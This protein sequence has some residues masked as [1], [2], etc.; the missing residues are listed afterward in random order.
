MHLGEEGQACLSWEPTPDPLEPTAHTTGYILY[1]RIDDAGFDDGRALDES[2]AEIALE[3]GHLYS[4]RVSATNEG[5][6]SFPSEVLSVGVVSEEAPTVLVVNN[7]DRVSA[8]VSFASRDSSYAGFMNRLDGGVPWNYDISY[9][10]NQHDFRR[11]IPWMD[12]DS[13]GFGASDSDYE[14]KVIAGNTFDYPAVHGRAWMEAGFNVVSASRSA[15]V[16]RRIEMNRYVYADLICG[17]QVTTQIGRRGAGPLRYQVF[18]AELRG[19]LEDFTRSGGSLLVSGAHVGSD[20]WEPIFDFEVDS[21]LKADYFTPGQQFA[22]EVL[23]YRWMTNSAAVTGEVKGVQNELGLEA[24]SRYVFNTQLNDKCYCVEAPDGL[25]PAGDGSYTVFRYAEN[26]I[27]AGVAYKGDYKTVILGFPVE[28]LETQE[29]VNG[30]I[31]EIA[32]FFA[33]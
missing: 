18:P 12:D 16:T 23:H 5:G 21:T 15:V 31:G 11:H 25:N 3:P 33:P 6:E 13:P 22:Q 17:K 29:Q 7:F 19:Q 9:I 4:F 30:L 8:P 20:L 14:T 26:N 10:G 28:T 27:S 32:R 2:H 24:G 1:T